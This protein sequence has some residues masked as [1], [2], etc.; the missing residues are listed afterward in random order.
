[1]NLRNAAQK[2]K[3]FATVETINDFVIEDNGAML[4]RE[5]KYHRI[6][7]LLEPLMEKVNIAWRFYSRKFVQN[8]KI[9]STT[10]RMS[11]TGD[12]N[13]SG[14]LKVLLDMKE[15]MEAYKQQRDIEGM[16]MTMR[17]MYAM[18]RALGY[19]RDPH[20]ADEYADT[21]MKGQATKLLEKYGLIKP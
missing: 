11:A 5:V 12:I 15:Q 1:M 8:P 17:T 20:P 13:I 7:D 19:K 21:D 2:F 16:V 18:L 3:A 9:S 14:N 10:S 6:P 4:V